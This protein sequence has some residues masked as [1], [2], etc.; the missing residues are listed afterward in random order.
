MCS[1]NKYMAAIKRKLLAS[2][3]LNKRN[4]TSS[5]KFVIIKFECFIVLKVY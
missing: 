2:H 1:S 3:T 5:F 4:Y